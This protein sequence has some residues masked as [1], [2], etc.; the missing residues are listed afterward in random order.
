MSHA[1]PLDL[2]QQSTLSLAE[3]SAQLSPTHTF[4][5]PER[6]LTTK[7]SKF[8]VTPCL[9]AQWPS[10]FRLS[11]NKRK[12][13]CV[14]ISPLRCE[15]K[16]TLRESQYVLPLKLVDIPSP[17]RRRKRDLT[18]PNSLLS[19]SFN[20]RSPIVTRYLFLQKRKY[21]EQRSESLLD[22]LRL[23]RAI[24]QPPGGKGLREH[25]LPPLK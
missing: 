8:R 21:P 22:N 15:K 23:L 3:E 19:L 9:R 24:K 5:S 1:G 14:G 20:E 11:E 18:R 13:K 2:E 16:K 17:E 10:P 7:H 4:L 25:R 6:F 12:G